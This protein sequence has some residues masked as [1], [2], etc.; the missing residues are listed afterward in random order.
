MNHLRSV[1]LLGA[2][3]AVVGSMSCG[4]TSVAVPEYT[5]AATVNQDA[6]G[7]VDAGVP[8]GWVV[9]DGQPE[10]CVVPE[11]LPPVAASSTVCSPRPGT[12]CVPD[13][14]FCLSK[15]SPFFYDGTEMSVLKTNGKREPRQ[16][17]WTPRFMLDRYPVTNAEY[18]AYVS[19]TGASPPPDLLQYTFAPDPSPGQGVVPRPTGWRQGQPDKRRMDHPVVGVTRAEAQAYCA[20]KGGRLPSVAE[21]MRAGQGPAPLTQR[22][23]WGSVF[24]YPAGGFLP[25]RM[26]AGPPYTSPV[27][28]IWGDL[29]P[30]GTHGLVSNVG[31]WIGTCEE[32]ARTTFASDA[33]L[34]LGSTGVAARCTDAVLTTNIPDISARLFVGQIIRS[35][36]VE[37]RTAVTRYLRERIGRGSSAFDTWRVITQDPTVSTLQDEAGNDYRDFAIGFRC[38]YEAP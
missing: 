16:I 9:E 29:G 14:W 20:A 24:P 34:V 2:A 6:G 5:G 1:G 27:D 22:Y 19:S 18:A 13:A 32:E 11:N 7:P 26:I 3:L 17:V 28:A 35:I 21:V 31:E 10:L 12:H 30:Y 25:P 38:A 36:H 37:G 33:P 15:W 8:D 4:A 23:P